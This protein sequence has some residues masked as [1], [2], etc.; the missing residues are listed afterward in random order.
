MHHVLT[1]P[2]KNMEM[3]GGSSNPGILAPDYH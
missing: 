3:A 1:K 2:A